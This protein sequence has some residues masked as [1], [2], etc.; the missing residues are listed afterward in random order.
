MR[1]GT[2][3]NR[4]RGAA[5]SVLLLFLSLCFCELCLRQL[6][7]NAQSMRHPTPALEADPQ[8]GWVP[9]PGHYLLYN[10]ELRPERF[11]WTILSD[12]S[13][14]VNAPERICSGSEKCEGAVFLGGSF[15]QGF[16]L[17][18]DESFAAL[19]K[20]D[21]PG[22]DVRNF[23][24]RAYGTYHNLLLL[25]RLLNV[26]GRDYS[27]YTFFYGFAVFHEDRNVLLSPYVRGLAGAPAIPSVRL[28]EGKL[29]EVAP[30]QYG[31]FPGLHG[32]RLLR[33]IDDV[34]WLI[35]DRLVEP[36]AR[37]IS[38]KLL[39]EMKQL[40]RSRNATF[41]VVLLD[42]SANEQKNYEEFFREEGITFVNLVTSVQ[43]EPFMRLSNDPHPNA[44]M[45]RYWYRNFLDWYR[46]FRN[47]ELP[48]ETP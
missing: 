18:D 14:S 2:R 15:M 28:S 37:T 3:G 5:G 47:S 10:P 17:S 8:L 34:L 31:F 45:I 46:P 16:G 42:G 35:R 25:R 33:L 43:R 9:K 19:Y 13:R 40:L 7:Y 38:E 39:L 30:R 20:Q 48:V 6:N 26:P 21:F 44:E 22:Q 24:V 4:F 11:S 41:I 12:R 27:G 36:D 32:I 23:A 1:S 29:L